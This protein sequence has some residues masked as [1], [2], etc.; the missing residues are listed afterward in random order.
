MDK[1]KK[2]KKSDST[3]KVVMLFP[4]PGANKSVLKPWRPG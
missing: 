2:K 4:F 3:K 1:D